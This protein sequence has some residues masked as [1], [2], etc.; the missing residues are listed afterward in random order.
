MSDTKRPG[1]DYTE[2][3]GEVSAGDTSAES[4]NDP[5]ASV[6]STGSRVQRDAESQLAGEVTTG[7]EP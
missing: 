6:Q 4:A 2:H 1:D 7:D 3:P 5:E